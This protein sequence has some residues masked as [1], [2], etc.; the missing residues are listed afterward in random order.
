VTL[1]PSG[2]ALPVTLP[3]GYDLAGSS[4][5]LQ[6]LETDPGASRGV[7]FTEGLE[8]TLGS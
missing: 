8:L 7:S 2:L 1:P 5:F 6:A 3:C 4:F